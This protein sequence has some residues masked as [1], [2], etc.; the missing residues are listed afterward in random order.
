MVDDPPATNPPCMLTS[1]LLNHELDPS[2]IEPPANL[3]ASIEQ[4]KELSVAQSASA[5]YTK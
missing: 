4:L 1:A 3:L 5:V 2:I